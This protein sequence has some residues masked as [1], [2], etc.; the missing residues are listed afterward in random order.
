MLENEIP[1]FVVTFSTQEVLCF[2]NVKTC[3]VIVGAEDRVELSLRH[4]PE[5]LPAVEMGLDTH[6]VVEGGQTSRLNARLRR[7][8][9]WLTMRRKF[10]PVSG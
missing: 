10:P 5:H 1:V 6:D 9:R 7:G 3:E 8:K 2:R 4:Y